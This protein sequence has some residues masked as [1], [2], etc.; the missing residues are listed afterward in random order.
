MG[1]APCAEQTTSSSCSAPPQQRTIGVQRASTMLPATLG[2]IHTSLMLQRLRRAHLSVSRTSP[3]AVLRCAQ[4]SC[5]TAYAKGYCVIPTLLATSCVHPPSISDPQRRSDGWCVL[6]A[7][8]G[9][10]PTALQEG[11]GATVCSRLNRPTSAYTVIS[12]STLTWARAGS[13]A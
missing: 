8:Y 1:K 11:A 9:L 6:G 13:T 4:H 7:P 2:C 3:Q 10:V 5:F 12:L